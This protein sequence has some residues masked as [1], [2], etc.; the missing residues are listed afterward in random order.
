MVNHHHEDDPHRNDPDRRARGPSDFTRLSDILPQRRSLEK[1]TAIC[2]GCGAEF[3]RY[4]ISPFGGR[5]EYCDRCIL[6]MREDEAKELE[7]AKAIKREE[8][9]ADSLPR[10]LRHKT[11]ENWEGQSEALITAHAWAEGFP[12]PGDSR[13]YQSLYIY[14]EVNGVGKTHLAAAVANT[15]IDRWDGDP[16]GEP[17]SPVRYV[18]GPNLLARILGSYARGEGETA[19][20]IYRSLSGVRLLV[21]DDLIKESEGGGPSAHTQR[22][23]FRLVDQRYMD[24]RP[25]IVVSNCDLDDVHEVLGTATASRLAEMSANTV[26][27]PLGE[28]RRYVR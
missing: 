15:I 3:R 7:V 12:Y 21:L 19:E 23:Y 16:F 14:N 1:E 20:E 10:K 27:K 18:T 6:A 26:I 4:P 17:A 13:G 25:M 5:R 11:F 2:L 9:R 24:E 8:L 22:A 28:D